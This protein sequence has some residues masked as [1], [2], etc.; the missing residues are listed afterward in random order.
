MSVI[1]GGAHAEA[2]T[3]AAPH[4]CEGWRPIAGPAIPYSNSEEQIHLQQQSS[5]D[6]SFVTS[7]YSVAGELDAR[8]HQQ[9]LPQQ[10]TQQQPQPEYTASAVASAVVSNVGVASADVGLQLPV[11]NA[12][13]FYYD[14]A[15]K[16]HGS[17][18][19][20]NNEVCGLF[21]FVRMTRDVKK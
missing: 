16:H 14:T 2:L 17:H 15:S 13:N 5:A 3:A 12:I 10:L 11:N 19:G 8:Q 20:G 1:A 21:G 7:G 9:Q 4:R 18:S 6:S